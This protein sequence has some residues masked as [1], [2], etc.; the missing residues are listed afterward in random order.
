ML[1]HTSIY[2]VYIFNLPNNKLKTKEIIIQRQLTITQGSNKI[3][4]VIALGLNEKNIIEITG[5]IIFRDIMYIIP[6]P[7]MDAYGTQ[8]EYGIRPY[9]QNGVIGLTSATAWGSV[10]LTLSIRYLE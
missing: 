1:V 3:D 5:N 9:V 8:R 6:S 10:P 2:G 7:M 4:D